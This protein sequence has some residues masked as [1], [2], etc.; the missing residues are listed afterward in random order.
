[1]RFFNRSM[2]T[3]PIT[4]GIVLP[5]SADTTVD[6]CILSP[7]APALCAGISP[8]ASRRA[9]HSLMCLD[10]HN[11]VGRGEVERE[12]CDVV[13]HRLVASRRAGPALPAGDLRGARLHR[14]DEVVEV[15]TEVVRKE[16]LAP[17]DRE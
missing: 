4:P 2:T 12:R 7:T 3:D 9:L 8:Q 13:R 16:P 11:D 6:Q 15:P 14:A 5:K 1:M 17:D 10:Q